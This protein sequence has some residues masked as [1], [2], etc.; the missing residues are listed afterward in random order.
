MTG[1][2]TQADPYI[3]SDVTDLQAIENDLSAYYELGGDIDASAT[4]GWN[5]GTGFIPI[6]YFTGQLDGKGYTID[7]LFSHRVSTDRSGLFRQVD[8]SLEIKSVTLTVVDILGDAQEGVGGLIGILWDGI[9]TNCHTTGTVAGARTGTLSLGGLVGE[10]QGGTITDCSSSCTI[11]GSGNSLGVGGLIG[12]FVSGG[13]VIVS[14]CSAT[15]DVTGISEVGGFVG[16]FRASGGSADSIINCYATGDVVGDGGYIGGFVGHFDGSSWIGTITE[17]YAEGDVTTTGDFVGGF[18]GLFELGAAGTK[19]QDCYARGNANG[20]DY[21]GGFTGYDTG[22]ILWQ[23]TDNCYSTGTTTVVG[24]NSGGFCG[25]QEAPADAITNCFW[26]TETSGDAT[27]DGGTGKTTAQMKTVAT[28][29]SA[30]W[31]I[32]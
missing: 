6:S 19:I 28:F 22:N 26:D 5:G 15:G 8:T 30:G 2:G 9:I 32:A 31:D 4:S 21:V 11:T 1:S 3:I 17:C 7:R 14:G 29:S 23:L 16:W 12:F 13:G 20:N 10:C 25:H 27:S 18:V 24:A